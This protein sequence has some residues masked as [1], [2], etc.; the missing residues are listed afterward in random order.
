V[1]KQK[2]I[3]LTNLHPSDLQKISE[4]P[5]E[6]SN[7]YRSCMVLQESQQAVCPGAALPLGEFKLTSSLQQI[8]SQ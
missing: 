7:E 8:N 3:Y 1:G 6:I 5:I 2:R 4:Y